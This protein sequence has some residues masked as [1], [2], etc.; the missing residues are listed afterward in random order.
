[1]FF[2]KLVEVSF[3]YYSSLL[4]K[5]KNIHVP[6]VTYHFGGGVQGNR[7]IHQVFLQ[8][9]IAFASSDI[10]L[11]V[12]NL[13]PYHINGYFSNME[14]EDLLRRKVFQESGLVQNPFPNKITEDIQFLF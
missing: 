9:G 13:H 14:Q 12:F 10:Y 6:V 8:P 4:D 1:M 11:G 3:C 5:S 2:K 7:V